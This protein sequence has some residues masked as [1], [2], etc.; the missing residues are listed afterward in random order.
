[1][2]HLSNMT[3]DNNVMQKKCLIKTKKWKQLRILLV[4]DT[5]N[6]FEK[7]NVWLK[8]KLLY[9]RKT[10]STNTRDKVLR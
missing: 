6:C 5:N 4:N 2:S 8:D 3:A 10:A 7:K 1:M 9:C